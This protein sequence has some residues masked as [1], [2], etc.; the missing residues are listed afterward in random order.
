M[1]DPRNCLKV[2]VFDDRHDLD[3][4]VASGR[5][6][7]AG[8][9]RTEQLADALALVDQQLG[10]P[11]DVAAPRSIAGRFRQTSMMSLMA[12]FRAGDERRAGRSA[13]A[14]E[15]AGAAAAGRRA[16][17][18]RTTSTRLGEGRRRARWRPRPRA[19]PSRALTTGS[20][21]ATRSSAKKSAARRLPSIVAEVELR[22]PLLDHEV[23]ELPRVDEELGDSRLLPPQEEVARVLASGKHDDPQ[24]EAAP[25]QE[26]DRAHRTPRCRRWSPS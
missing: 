22:D 13:P 12:F 23:R 1:S 6:A 20:S 26:R 19:R 4:R 5:S 8:Q 9:D 7:R 17:R 10:K 25:E 11:L 3:R 15:S 21:I 14:A 24:V 18:L 2:V 16:G